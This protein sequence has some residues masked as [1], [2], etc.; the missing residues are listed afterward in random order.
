MTQD[1]L[2]GELSARLERLQRVSASTAADLARLR[3]RAFDRQAAIAA[4]LRL[5]GIRARL[6][7]EE[8]TT[9]SQGLR[10]TV[11][12]SGFPATPEVPS[13]APAARRL[14]R[15][16]EDGG[17][18]PHDQDDHDSRHDERRGQRHRPRFRHVVPST[19]RDAAS[20]EAVVG[21]P[22]PHCLGEAARQRQ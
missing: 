10:P 11:A 9:A 17:Q 19:P 13:T 22:R 21:R 7:D 12:G 5:F 4:D 18:P 14:T 3:R 20:R 15:S 2:I 16:I 1:Y 6:L 8:L